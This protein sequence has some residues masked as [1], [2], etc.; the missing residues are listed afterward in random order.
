MKIKQ[1]T[2]FRPTTVTLETREELSNFRKILIQSISGSGL[3][4]S[5]SNEAIRDL[6]AL[7]EQTLFEIDMEGD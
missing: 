6:A 1:E 4:N 2:R 7:I 3:E 5:S